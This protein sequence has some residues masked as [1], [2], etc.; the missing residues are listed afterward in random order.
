MPHPLQ[1][2]F[3]EADLMVWAKLSSYTWVGYK[4]WLNSRNPARNPYCRLIVGLRK[5]RH[6]TVRQ[7]NSSCATEVADGIIHG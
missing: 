7:S 3:D 1:S 2:T 4:M 6:M 5:V